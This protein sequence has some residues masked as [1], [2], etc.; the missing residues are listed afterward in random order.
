MVT[1]DQERELL[2]T[3]EEDSEEERQEL[4]TAEKKVEAE[5]V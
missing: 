2:V 4:D 1:Y 3:D 5:A